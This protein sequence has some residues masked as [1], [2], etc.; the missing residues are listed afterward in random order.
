MIVKSIHQNKV[1]QI[2][3]VQKGLVTL[4]KKSQK[5]KKSVDT[6]KQRGYN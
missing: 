2:A 4:I 6:L 3:I 1:S 5:I